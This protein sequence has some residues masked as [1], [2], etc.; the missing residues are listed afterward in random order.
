MN[1]PLL[2]QI[3]ALTGLPERYV[4]EEL[5]KLIQRSDVTPEEISLELLREILAA[6]LQETLLEAKKNPAALSTAGFEVPLKES[7]LN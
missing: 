4:E 2:K 5:L 6:Y 3:I 7:E 1:N